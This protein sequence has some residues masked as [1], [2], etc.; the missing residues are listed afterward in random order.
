MPQ[1]ST[2]TPTP[3]PPTQNMPTYIQ[4]TKTN[5]NSFMKIKIDSNIKYKKRECKVGI[6]GS[7]TIHCFACHHLCS[8]SSLLDGKLHN[9]FTD[10]SVTFAAWVL[11]GCC[12]DECHKTSKTMLLMYLLSVCM[13]IILMTS[14]CK[15]GSQSP[16][17]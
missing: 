7:F 8:L 12:S 9:T 1:L 5:K 16:F 14:K 10:G 6:F 15:H 2:P 17:F 3:H 11:S 4:K 13:G